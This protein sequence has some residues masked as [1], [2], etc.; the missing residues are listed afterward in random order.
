MNFD[1]QGQRIILENKYDVR[2][3]KFLLKK[4]SFSQV[5]SQSLLAK[6]QCKFSSN[7]SDSHDYDFQSS[8]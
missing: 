5:E 2:L 7:S 3:R 6:L 4:K 8:G 1:T